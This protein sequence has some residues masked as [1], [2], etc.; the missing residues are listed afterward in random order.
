MADDEMFPDGNLLTIF[1]ESAGTAGVHGKAFSNAADSRVFGG[2]LVAFPDEADPT[3][4]RIFSRFYFDDADS[5]LDKLVGS[6]IGLRWP[7][8]LQ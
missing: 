5:Q 4:D 3:Q 1:A 2:A 6:N 7:L 8:T